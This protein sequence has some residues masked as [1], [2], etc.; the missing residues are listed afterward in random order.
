MR[1]TRR[2][3]LGCMRG[4]GERGTDSLMAPSC[5]PDRTS[6]SIG[7]RTVLMQSRS[8]LRSNPRSSGAS[9]WHSGPGAAPS[10]A[11]ST[12]AV[13]LPDQRSCLTLPTEQ[14]SLPYGQHIIPDG[15]AAVRVW[16][17]EWDSNPRAT[18]GAAGFQDRCNQPLCHPSGAASMP[19][20]LLGSSMSLALRCAPGCARRGAPCS[21][22]I[23]PGNRVKTGARPL[24]HPSG[25]ASMPPVLLGSSRRALCCRFGL[26]RAAKYP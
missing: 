21:R 17:R 14:Q 3:T 7:T 16:R 10:P 22:S 25:A 15:L 5:R 13:W 12:S 11:R 6:A 26:R 19:P 1:A 24:C 9:R 4:S 8:A 23:A 2:G 18:F 20:V